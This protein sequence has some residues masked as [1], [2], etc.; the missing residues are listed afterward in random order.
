MIPQS[1]IINHALPTPRSTSH[2]KTSRGFTLIEML[3]VVAIIGILASLLMP[4]LAGAKRKA[5][6]IKCISNLRQVNT[7]LTL[8]AADHDGEFPPRRHMTN[9]WIASLQ[10]YYHDAKV[11]K[12]PQD[13]FL[14]WRSYII[15][16]WND[17]FR[18]TLSP[19][20]FQEYD[21]WRW[22]HGIKESVIVYPS[23]T[24]TFGEKKT[25]SNHVHMDF[26]QGN[27]GNDVEQVDHQRHKTGG[28]AKGGAHFAFAD[29]SVRFLPYG[30]SLSPVNLW[31]VKD[32]WRNATAK[33]IDGRPSSS[34]EIK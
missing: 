12:C 30:N 16:G 3:V 21:Q 8:Y 14:E 13:R 2:S 34:T 20:E 31:A 11:L 27:N 5:N 22:P 29:G 10:P 24:I 7:A 4:S 28:G 33:P 6:A 1:F 26:N 18:S 23:E 9:S 25:G 15:N 17:Y 32:E 19:K